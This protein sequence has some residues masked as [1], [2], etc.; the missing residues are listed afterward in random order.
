MLMI[1]ASSADA[2][3]G[4]SRLKLHKTD[5]RTRLHDDSVTDQ[6][7]VMLHTATIEEYDPMPAID[8]WNNAGQRSKHVGKPKESDPA[9]LHEEAGQGESDLKKYMYMYHW[10][11]RTFHLINAEL[12]VTACH[13][14]LALLG[15][16]HSIA[17]D[18]NIRNHSGYL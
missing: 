18:H 16:T 5:Q 8:L 12:L 3:H 17:Q 7:M 11:Q 6:L 9:V 4:F 10:S 14:Y 15:N 1:P 2:E 13:Y